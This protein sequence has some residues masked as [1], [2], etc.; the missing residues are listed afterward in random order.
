MGGGSGED[1]WGPGTPTNRLGTPCPLALNS[2][3]VTIS[4]SFLCKRHRNV[5][6]SYMLNLFYG[7]P[8]SPILASVKWDSAKRDSAKQEDTG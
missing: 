1:G 3:S 8:V 2:A 7:S 5:C 6:C 4:W